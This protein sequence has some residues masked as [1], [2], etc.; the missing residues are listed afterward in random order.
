MNIFETFYKN[1]LEGLFFLIVIII[2]F[3]SFTD[4]AYK[5]GM[6]AETLELQQI[7]YFGFLASFLAILNIL[8]DKFFGIALYR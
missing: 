2:L 8:S 5:L 3:N 4:F 1:I 6:V 7:Q